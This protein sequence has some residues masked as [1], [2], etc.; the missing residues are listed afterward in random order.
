MRA[1]HLV[2][3]GALAVTALAAPT[4]GAAE[5]SKTCAYGGLAGS[6]RVDRL[7]LPD[8]SDFLNLSLHAERSPRPVGTAESWHL[9]AG[10]FVIEEATGQLVA[11]RVVSD[12]AA[13]RRTVVEDGEVRHVDVVTPG[14][15]VPYKRDSLGNTS[16]LAPGQYLVVAFGVDGSDASPN[17]TWGG[18]VEVSGAP[19]CTS[20]SSASSIFEA[21][22]ADFTDGRQVSTSGVGSVSEATLQE[23]LAGNLVVGLMRASHQ[24]AGEATLG[25]QFP[26]DRT[27]TVEDAVVPFVASPGAFHWTAEVTGVAPVVSIAALQVVL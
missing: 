11:H 14:P 9:S 20:V 25:Y 3:L 12:G 6:W 27:G 10:L 26:G 19:A 13:N 23:D 1:R 22:H 24:V 17:A 15:D 7:D 18:E 4:V 8:G 5:G 21:D 2:A 16:S